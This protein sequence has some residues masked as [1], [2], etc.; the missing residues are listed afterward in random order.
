MT[1]IEKNI[2][3]QL[4][5]YPELKAID[6]GF[7]WQLGDDSTTIRFVDT[8]AETEFGKCSIAVIESRFGRRFNSPSEPLLSRLNRRACYG[9]Y[10][11]A[12]DELLLRAAWSVYEREPGVGWVAQMLLRCFGDQLAFGIGNAHAIASPDA[13]AANRASLAYPRCWQ[14]R[15]SDD[16]LESV[17][18]RFRE[19]GWVSSVLG[20]SLVLEVPLNDGARSRVI[21]P[22]AET[23]LLHV[24]LDVPHPI[25]GVGYAATIALPIDPTSEDIPTWAWKLNAAEHRL[26]D[27][28]PRLGAWGMRSL[29]HELVYS[30][31][32]PTDEQ[33]EKLVGNFMSWMIQRVLWLRATYWA[34]GKGLRDPSSA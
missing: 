20:Q 16:A 27:F 10:N 4:E 9:S 1:E 29:E 5:R 34:Q 25:A 26:G 14:T 3:G 21:D 24:S 32:W 11:Y 13:L 19:H 28:V 8:D 23:A 12:D 17:A 31:F 2:L 30:M 7:I 15:L 6:R 33:H 22:T 18:R